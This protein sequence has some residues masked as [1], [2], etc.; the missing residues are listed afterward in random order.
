RPS[1]EGRAQPFGDGGEALGVGRLAHVEDV[2]DALGLGGDLGQRDV[3]AELRQG[4][5]DR[6]EDAGAIVGEH[7]DHRVMLADVVVDLDLR[8]A[9][10]GH[11]ARQAALPAAALPQVGGRLLAAEDAGEVL[12]DP[13]PA[14]VGG[15]DRPAA[16]VAY[17]EDV[18]RQAGGL[19]RV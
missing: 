10:G 16:A 8:R 15:G 13:L 11:R 4:A 2:G 7:V 18:E 1:S 5:G 17:G 19:E 14:R 12:V 6:V 3:Q 9:L